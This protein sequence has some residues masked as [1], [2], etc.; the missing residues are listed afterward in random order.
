M[1]KESCLRLLENTFDSKDM[2]KKKLVVVGL[3]F[4]FILVLG[5][6]V[7]PSLTGFATYQ[8][9]QAYEENISNLKSKVSALNMN[10]SSY[11]DFNDKLLNRLENYS[12]KISN[13]KERIKNLKT[14]FN[15]TINEYNESLSNLSSSLNRKEE[16][17]EELKQTIDELEIDVNQSQKNYLDLAN[18]WANNLCCKE[19]VD[20]PN[21]KYYKVENNSVV[22]LEN[23]TKQI[24]C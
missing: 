16:K 24:N 12:S 8:G 22:C 7:G 2:D 4:V 13:L 20:D 6:L 3:V 9:V 19:R 14:D 23:G 15:L 21:I 10:L 5:M 17:I 11:D 1:S 18:N